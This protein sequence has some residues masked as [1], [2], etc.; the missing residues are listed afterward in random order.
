MPTCSARSL[1]YELPHVSQ[2]AGSGATWVFGTATEVPPEGDPAHDAN[3]D[4]WRKAKR[5]DLS[6]ER[7]RS[8]DAKPAG[9]GTSQGEGNRYADTPT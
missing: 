7:H 9:D 4:D 6:D 8:G 3:Q 1:S 2:R 5:I